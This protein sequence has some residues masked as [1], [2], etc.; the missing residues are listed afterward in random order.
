[1]F[2][3]NTYSFLE[4]YDVK[5]SLLLFLK[6]SGG[7]VMSRE[8]NQSAIRSTLSLENI[9]IPQ[10]R[11]YPTYISYDREFDCARIVFT[12][13][14]EPYT[15]GFGLFTPPG[16]GKTLYAYN[17]AAKFGAYLVKVDCNSQ[18]REDHL[19]GAY[20]TGLNEN[21]DVE[22]VW[23][24]GP[25]PLAVRL[26][27][28]GKKV[29]VLMNEFNLLRPDIQPLL[30]PLLDFQK[31]ITLTSYGNE[32]V[33]LTRGCII[34][35]L[36]G[37]PN[38]I[39][40]NPIPQNVWSRM[41]VLLKMDIGDVI[42]TKKNV[43]TEIYQ[44]VLR[45]PKKNAQILT[46]LNEKLVIAYENNDAITNPPTPRVLINL[47]RHIRPIANAN[48]LTMKEK[49]EHIEYIIQ[50]VLINYVAKDRDEAEYV[51]KVLEGMDMFEKLRIAA[52]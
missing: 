9:K 3:T 45:I 16:M 42:R 30:N 43:L 32:T 47:F 14:P 8:T 50:T 44:T 5:V 25:L 40:V 22:T 29:V 17:L 49:R 33:K 15:V 20:R 4:E 10:K 18:M 36:T 28:T 34:F 52:A 2:L 27:N 7:D 26:A 6:L 46:L 19:L 12:Q 38:I 39:G 13:Q 37:N 11:E 35:V 21:G 31:S 1:M 24:D 23:E 51:L 48:L 41:I